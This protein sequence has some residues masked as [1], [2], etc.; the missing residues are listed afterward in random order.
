MDQGQNPGTKYAEE[1]LK[2][3]RRA[4]SCL[5]HS[6]TLVPIVPGFCRQMFPAAA[7]EIRPVLTLHRANERQDFRMLQFTKCRNTQLKRRQLRGVDIQGNY[8]ARSLA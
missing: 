8:F 4:D 3:A 5:N 7:I 2:A 1:V 6:G